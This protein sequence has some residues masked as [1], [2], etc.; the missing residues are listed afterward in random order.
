MQN[1]RLTN[2]KNQLRPKKLEV[3]NVRN[4][5]M[6]TKNYKRV[7]WVEIRST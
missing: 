4:L 5:K 7:K 3:I 2:K 1:K 6:K